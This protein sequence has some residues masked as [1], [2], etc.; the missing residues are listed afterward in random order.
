MTQ[1][2]RGSDLGVVVILLV[3]KNTSQIR[4]LPGTPSAN[5]NGGAIAEVFIDPIMLFK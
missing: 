1:H 5:N 2:P 4:S 3:K